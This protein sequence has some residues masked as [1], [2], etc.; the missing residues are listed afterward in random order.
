MEMEILEQR[1][2]NKL[3][4]SEFA[5]TKTN[6]APGSVTGEPPRN[7]TSRGGLCF[8]RGQSLSIFF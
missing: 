1:R 4:Q 8:M 2:Y 5:S 3:Q 6:R 7:I